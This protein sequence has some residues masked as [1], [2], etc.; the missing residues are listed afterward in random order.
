VN[1]LIVKPSS[2][3][4]IVHT[5]P[6]VQMLRQHYP[7]AFIAWV[8][9]DSFTGFLSLYPGVDEVIPFRRR[10]WARL[11]RWPEFLGFLGELRQHRFD[12]AVDF[13]GLFRSGF[14]AWASGAPRRLGF[15]NAREGAGFFYTERIPLPANLRHALERNV[16]LVQS[17]FG[18]AADASMPELA[19]PHD[20]VREARRLMRQ[21]GIEGDGPV[22]AVGPAARWPSKRWPPRFFAAVLDQVVQALPTVRCWLLGTAD[23]GAEAQAVVQACSQARPANLVGTTDLATLAEML[24]RSDAL[25]TNDSGPMHL[26]AALSVPTIAL[27]GA[28]DPELT[29]PYGSAHTVFRSTCDAAPCFSRDCLHKN[30]QCSEGTHPGR[31]AEAVVAT[32]ATARERDRRTAVLPTDEETE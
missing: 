12:V 32:L 2:L 10:R 7:D 6:A 5:L 14:I 9:N 3:G 26:A 8:A 18:I 25:L 4:D 29:G 30:R 23:E 21:H 27:F 13:Q 31:V 22:L 16:F 24:R 15:Q 19:R 20:C 28:T 17:A 1:V 11:H